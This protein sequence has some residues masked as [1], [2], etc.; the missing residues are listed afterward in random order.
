MVLRDEL[1]PG[2]SA[3]V[4]VVDGSLPSVPDAFAD[5]DCRN[6]RVML[7]AI[8]EIEPAIMAARRRYGGDRLAVIMGTSTSGIAEGEEALRA[9]LSEGAWPPSF[10][11]SQQELGSLSSFVAAYLDLSGPAYTIATACSS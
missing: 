3:R 5:L 9:R 10:R 4:G 2:R 1:I 7:A 6:N 11:Y 8:E